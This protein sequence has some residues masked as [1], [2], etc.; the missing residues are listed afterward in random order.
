M[1]HFI[2]TARGARRNAKYR[3]KLWS[4]FDEQ[5]TPDM[6]RDIVVAKDGG[7]S[8]VASLWNRTRWFSALLVLATLASNTVVLIQADLA[9][10]SAS[11]SKRSNDFFVSKYIIDGFLSTLCN[12]AGTE[13]TYE[14]G[15]EIICVLELAG[16]LTLW[17]HLLWLIV[18]AGLA[19]REETKWTYVEKA[20]WVTLPELSSYSAMRLLHFV[21]PSVMLSDIYA[22]MGYTAHDGWFVFVKHWAKL[23]ISRWVFFVVGID[24]LLL[25]MRE[26]EYIT[27]G[28]NL[29]LLKAWK[30]L[31]F[32]SQILGIVQ[33]GMFVRERLFV[34]IFAGEDSQMQPREAALRDVWNAM[35]AR[36]IRRKFSFAR[37]LAIMLSF[38]DE[39]FQKLV[40]NEQGTLHDATRGLSQSIDEQGLHKIMRG[41]SSMSENNRSEL[42]SDDGSFQSSDEEAMDRAG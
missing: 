42:I 39:D 7:F 2:K 8:E 4:E 18:S 41:Y 23:I 19:S 26:N 32:I 33:L 13:N 38:S 16:L 35:L 11:A 34:F 27:H 40:L 3:A 28:E 21:S 6:F 25:K 24:A 30:L 14:G 5:A 1:A 17:L 20:F 29:S 12:I 36:Q 9:A 37:W 31:I 22:E 10:M 15:V